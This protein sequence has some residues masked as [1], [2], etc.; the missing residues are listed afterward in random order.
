MEALGLSPREEAHLRTLIEEVSKSSEI[1]GEHL[2]QKQVRSSIARKRGHAIQMELVRARATA[3]R[4]V[5]EVFKDEIVAVA[6]K[7]DIVAAAAMEGVS[8]GAPGNDVIAAI[9]VDE[10]F[11]S[12]R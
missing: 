10:V 12:R 7:H 5:I 9:A 11:P 8:S 4:V 1:E 3:R 6:A 2:D